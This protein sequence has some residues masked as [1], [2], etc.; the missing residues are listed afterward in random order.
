MPS[1]VVEL[2]RTVAVAMSDGPA[3]GLALLD[4]LAGKLDGYHLL[5]A[6]RAD[7]LR[8]LGRNAEAAECYEAALTLAGTEAERRYLT[9]RISET[10]VSVPGIPERRVDDRPRPEGPS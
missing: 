3:A 8:R 5:P 1:P 2:N 9:R 7:F 4:T 10:G 6:T